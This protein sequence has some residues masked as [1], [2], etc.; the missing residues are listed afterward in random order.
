MY[1]K[2]ANAE[3]VRELELYAENTREIYDRYTMPVVENLKK[4]YQKGCYEKE[5]AIVAWEHV[6]TA[7][8]KMYHKEFCC[9]GRYFDIFT[10]ADRR[11]TAKILESVYFEEY[12][13][14]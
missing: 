4:K 11:E 10:A 2:T 6:A 7:A 1:K 9:S 14:Q 5:K 8:A 3:N 13:K 12:I